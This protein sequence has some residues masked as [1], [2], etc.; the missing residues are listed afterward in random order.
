MINIVFDATTAG[1]VHL[2]KEPGTAE[3]IRSTDS[4]LAANK[5]TEYDFGWK[6]QDTGRAR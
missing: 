3:R 2:I 6:D 1:S 5:N 4:F